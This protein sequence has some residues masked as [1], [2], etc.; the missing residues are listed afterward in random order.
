MPA[1]YWLIMPLPLEQFLPADDLRVL[2]IFDFVPRID[3]AGGSVRR[4]LLLGND[5]FEV[6]GTDTLK[7]SNAQCLDVVGIHQ[8]GIYRQSCQQFSQLVLAVGQLSRTQILPIHKEQVERKK[9]LCS[10]VE[11]RSLNLGLP[12]RSRHT[13]SPSSTAV[14]VGNDASI[15]R[16]RSWN[17]AN[18]FPFREI[19]SVRRWSIRARALKP[20][21]FSSKTQSGWSNATRH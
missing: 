11:H 13:I 9:A 21:Y 15:F 4:E 2:P 8:S 1:R 6:E 16:C 12:L 19:S 7:Q 3:F 17:E 10:T 14:S 20:S 18:A 5:A